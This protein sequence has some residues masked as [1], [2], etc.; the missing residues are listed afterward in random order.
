[1]QG[2]FEDEQGSTAPGDLRK[3]KARTT[4]Q[5]H[6]VNRDGMHVDSERGYGHASRRIRNLS[7]VQREIVG[8]GV[9]REKV[10]T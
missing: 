6:V 1:M 8:P 3:A 5:R 2:G 9:D 7:D 4:L 10:R